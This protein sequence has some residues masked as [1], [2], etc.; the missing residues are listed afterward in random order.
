[1]VAAWS[2]IYTTP[3]GTGTGWDQAMYIGAARNLLAGRGVTVAWGPDTGKPLTHFPPLYPLVLALGGP[4]GLDPWGVARYLNAALRA[5]DLVMVSLLAWRVGGRS[6]LAALIAA[7]LM[8]TS[9][10]MEFVHGSAW[11]EPLFLVL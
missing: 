6:H 1:L 9:V 11:S 5:V 3:W 4:L 7:F 2:V 8:L 10:H